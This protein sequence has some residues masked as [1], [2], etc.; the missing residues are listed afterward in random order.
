MFS[1]YHFRILPAYYLCQSVNST[2]QVPSS[3]RT[4]LHKRTNNKNTPQFFIQKTVTW[5]DVYF[6]SV[7]CV[8]KIVWNSCGS[9]TI[10]T[11]FLTQI[12]CF[13]VSKSIHD[14]YV[15]ICDGVSVY[16]YKVA[17]CSEH[18]VIVPVA[19]ALLSQLQGQWSRTSCRFL[20]CMADLEERE[21]R[22]RMVKDVSHSRTK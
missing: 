11:S 17:C 7:G 8:G 19:F 10:Q 20:C 13:V 6:I 16:T 4:T 3:C 22:T 9:F 5:C 18:A 2:W 15:Y 14:I 21:E 1:C 12:C